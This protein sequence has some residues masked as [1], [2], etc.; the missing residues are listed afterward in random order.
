MYVNFFLAV[1]LD[2]H[3][4]AAGRRDLYPLWDADMGALKTTLNAVTNVGPSSYTCTLRL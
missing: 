2:R 3:G 1:R 4:H